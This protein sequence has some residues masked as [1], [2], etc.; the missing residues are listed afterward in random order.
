[1]KKILHDI[2]L[3]LGFILLLGGLLLY[4]FNKHGYID[5]SIVFCLRNGPNYIC[6]QTMVFAKEAITI[7]ESVPNGSKHCRRWAFFIY[8]CHSFPY[9]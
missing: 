5:Y 8:S 7:I 3:V 1:M 4:A 2:S 6:I 9:R